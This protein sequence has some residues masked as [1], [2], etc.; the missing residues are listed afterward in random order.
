VDHSRATRLLLLLF[1]LAVAVSVV[2]YVDNYVNYADYPL[3]AEDAAL[4]APS[5]ELIA[6][7]WFV[8]TAA[9]LVGVGHYTSLGALDMVWWR[10]THVVADILCGIG[11]LA[12]ALWAAAN[13]RRL[14]GSS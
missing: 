12:F 4:P 3:P 13:G 10:H 1:G 9:G 8:F 5:A 14:S 6:V 11:V 7:S 2:H